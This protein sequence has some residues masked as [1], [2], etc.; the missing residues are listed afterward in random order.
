MNEHGAQRRYP[1]VRAE[2][3]ALVRTIDADVE[4]FARTNAVSV[5]GCGM[6][7]RERFDEGVAVELM[8]TLDQRVIHLIGRTVYARS[9]EGDRLE[10]GV[11]FLD[12]AQEDRE[13]L[14]ELISSGN[15]R[16]RSVDYADAYG[17]S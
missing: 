4:G 2:H 6:L 1:R 7:T 10:V 12:V 15:W 9:V 11:E 17:P 16:L 5:G 14:E 13:L 8:L 3:T